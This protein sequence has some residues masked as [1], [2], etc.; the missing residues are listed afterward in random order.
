MRLR[1]LLAAGALLA[2]AALPAGAEPN[3]PLGLCPLLPRDW[4]VGFACDHFDPEIGLFYLS[5]CVGEAFLQLDGTYTYTFFDATAYAPWATE[6]GTEC[7]RGS[8]KASQTVPAPATTFAPQAV[9]GITYDDTGLPT[10]TRWSVK[11]RE[12]NPHGYPPGV[13]Y[14][15]DRICYYV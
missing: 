8:V 5:E 11:F 9:E 4:P 10:C 6:I 14:Y 3:D 15:T 1:T 12:G 7:W 2:T 13:T